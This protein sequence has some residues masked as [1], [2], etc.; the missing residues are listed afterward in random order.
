M[1]LVNFRIMATEVNVHEAKTHLSRFLDRALA[2]EDIAIMRAGHPLVRLVP[3]AEAPRRRRVGTAKGDFVVP[4]AFDAP[5]PPGKL[6]L[7]KP[8]SPY[9]ERQLEQNGIRPLT[10]RWTH[11]TELE[12]LPPLQRDPFDRIIAAQA[13]AEGMALLTAD[14]AFDA[15]GVTFA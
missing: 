12:S 11:L 14:R 7:P 5:L 3:V 15:Y 10:F 9:L 8:T 13:R 4:E 2:G 6:Q 1:D